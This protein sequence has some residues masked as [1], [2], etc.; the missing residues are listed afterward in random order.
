M[1][2]LEKIK[3]ELLRLKLGKDIQ[4]SWSILF[5]YF[6]NSSH[7]IKIDQNKRMLVDGYVDPEEDEKHKYNIYTVIGMDILVKITSYDFR[8]ILVSNIGNNF[9][10]YSLELNEKSLE[11]IPEY[12]IVAS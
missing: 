10:G 6:N 4:E 3:S 11:S 5:A 7:L 2:N 1:N 9:K 12:K 8:R